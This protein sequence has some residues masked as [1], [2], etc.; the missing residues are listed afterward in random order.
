MVRIQD[1][2]DEVTWQMYKGQLT[3]KQEKTR[4]KILKRTEKASVLVIITNF[5]IRECLFDID[6]VFVLYIEAII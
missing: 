3:E 5:P 4:E 2:A 6:S 1:D